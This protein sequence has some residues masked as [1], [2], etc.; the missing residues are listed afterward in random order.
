MA[1][2]QQYGLQ[3]TAVEEYIPWGG[4]VEPSVMKQKDG[5]MFS[6]IAYTPYRRAKEQEVPVIPFCRGWVLWNE[7]QQRAD[8][9]GRDFLI[10]CWNPF[11]SMAEQYVDNSLDPDIDKDKTVPYFVSVVDR[12]LKNLQLV[13]S[14]N[15]LTYQDI[16]DICSFSLSIGD[17]YEKMPDVPLYIEALLSGEIDFEFGANDIYIN[18][19][20]LYS[21]TMMAGYDTDTI[22]GKLKHTAFRHTKRL[23]LFNPKQAE[24]SLKKYTSRWFPSRSVLKKEA[25]KGIL[26]AYNGYYTDSFLFL[27]DEKAQETF[28][29]YFENM[30]N[31]QGASYIVE[32]F[33]LKETFWG[34]LPGLFLANTKPPIRGFPTLGDF[35]HATLVTTVKKRDILEDAKKKII[36]TPVDIVAHLEDYEPA[37][38]EDHVSN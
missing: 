37:K 26:G 27:L 13:T 7:H 12:V 33:G 38:E 1:S 15:L 19:K 22:Y 6:I 10:V 4:I 5:S 21:V 35:L 32:E 16:L 14:A 2:L 31:A 20:R 34:S 9:L 3:S 29:A 24:K 25:L 23:V 8:A 36:H 11:Y 17:H 28:P 18:K 30:L